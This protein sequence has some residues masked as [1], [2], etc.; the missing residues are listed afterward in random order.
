MSTIG[1]V[2]PAHPLMFRAVGRAALVDQHD[3]RLDVLRLQLG[4]ERVDRVGLVVEFETLDAGRAHD[5]RR[6]LEGQAD[7]GDLGAVEVLDRVGREERLVRRGVD[8]VGGEEV[9]VGAA[10]RRA[11]L[12]AVDR[13]AAAVRHAQEFG[14]ALVELVVAH[15]VEVEP[16]R[17]SSPRSSARRGTAPTGAGWR[18]SGRRR[19]R[20]SSWGS[21]PR[22]SRR[23]WRG[24]RRRRRAWCR[25]GRRSRSAAGG[26]RGSR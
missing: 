15:G 22:G 18:R 20:R 26:C 5:D 24:R 1:P 7:E 23:G 21:S 10:E 16:D 19:R 2:T 14:G 17:R 8:D 6:A 13:V 4:D 9:E 11:V 3:D 12:A 25:P